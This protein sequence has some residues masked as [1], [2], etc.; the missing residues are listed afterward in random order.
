MITMTLRIRTRTRTKTQK[1]PMKLMIKAPWMISSTPT[2]TR[3]KA[4]RTVMHRLRTAQMTK[5]A[6]CVTEKAR[7][8]RC[9]L[10]K[11]LGVGAVPF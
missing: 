11:R 7:R 10:L 1:I 3:S 5:S 2:M 6:L 8:G 4:V 9:A